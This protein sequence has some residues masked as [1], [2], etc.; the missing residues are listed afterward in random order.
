DANQS[1]I[2]QL[3]QMMRQRRIRNVELNAD[4]ADDQALGMRGEQKL[5]DAQPGLGS[6]RRKHVRVTRNLFGI[7]FSLGSRH[8]NTSVIISMILEIWTEASAKTNYGKTK[9]KP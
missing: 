3:V 7:V 8:T 4:I 6:H 2:L 1:F 9:D 5:H